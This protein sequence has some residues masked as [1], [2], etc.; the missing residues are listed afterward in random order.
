MA[1]MTNWDIAQKLLPFTFSDEK[2]THFSLFALNMGDWI[3]T[4][5]ILVSARYKYWLLSLFL[6]RYFVLA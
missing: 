5:F 3:I 4:F 2:G 6:F 1:N